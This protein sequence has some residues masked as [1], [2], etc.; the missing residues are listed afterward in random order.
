MRHHRVADVMTTDII[1]VTPQTSFR[2]LARL[3]VER[4]VGVLPVLASDG[5]VTGIV[6]ETDLLN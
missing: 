2:E 6:R 1:A 3:L 4:Q 5:T